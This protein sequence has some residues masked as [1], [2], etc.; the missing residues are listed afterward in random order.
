M[1]FLQHWEK[2]RVSALSRFSPVPEKRDERGSEV[3]KK[4]T[5]R[6]GFWFLGWAI[7][8]KHASYDHVRIKDL[9]TRSSAVVVNFGQREGCF[10]LLSF[11]TALQDFDKCFC[12]VYSLLRLWYEKKSIE[13]RAAK[14]F[15][16]HAKQRH[17]QVA[18][19]DKT[20]ETNI[21]HGSN[22]CTVVNVWLQSI[23]FHIVQTQRLNGREK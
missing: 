12:C 5:A 15:C 16:S 22:D 3:W 8:P 10:P 4:C 19:A 11:L 23:L 1:V 17:S 6:K 18:Q 7:C 20:V 2:E 9:W 13:W 21:V 14:R